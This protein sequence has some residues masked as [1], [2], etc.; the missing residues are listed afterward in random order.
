MGSGR[1]CRLPP[2]TNSCSVSRLSRWLCWTHP[3]GQRPP[4]TRLSPATCLGLAP[5]L[6]CVAWEEMSTNPRYPRHHPLITTHINTALQGSFLENADIPVA[7]G[8]LF[9]QRVTY[10]SS[11]TN[12]L[13]HIPNLAHLSLAHN[14]KI[15][16]STHPCTRNIPAQKIKIYCCT[17]MLIAYTLLKQ[18][19]LAHFY[20][21]FLYPS[22]E[23]SLCIFSRFEL[24][25]QFYYRGGNFV[26]SACP[27]HVTSFCPRV[28][29]PTLT[30]GSCIKLHAWILWKLAPSL[31]S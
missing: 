14:H 7:P 25:P 20:D 9:K 15:L 26:W 22:K 13:S 29:P 23:L 16:M 19:F 24:S 28:F 5:L 18:A 17:L 8:V 12:L 3:A 31:H 1:L 10:Q 11:R 4:P 2:P 21:P 30:Q 27:G 6:P